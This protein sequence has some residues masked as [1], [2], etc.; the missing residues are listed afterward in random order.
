MV[1]LLSALAVALIVTA[2][3][4]RTEWRRP[5]HSPAR[6]IYLGST[7]VLFVVLAI[8]PIAG[9]VGYVGAHAAEYLLVVRWRIRGAGAKSAAGDGVGALVR[10]I[11]TDGSIALY[12]IAVV[13]L[14]AGLHVSAAVRWPSRSH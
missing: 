13:A 6:F 7:A 2:T 5:V 14:I 4:V 12:A 11:G 9:F 8:E 10:R 1:L 3:W